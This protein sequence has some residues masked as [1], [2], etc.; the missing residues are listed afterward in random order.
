MRELD[1]G[2]PENLDSRLPQNG[3][4]SSRKSRFRAPGNHPKPG[5]P[6]VSKQRSVFAKVAISSSRQPTKTWIPRYIKTGE[7]VGGAALIRDPGNRPKSAISDHKTAEFGA[8]SPD[9]ELRGTSHPG[10]EDPNRPGSAIST[11]KAPIG[12][13]GA[14][15]TD[16]SI[17]G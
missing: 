12:R 15:E 14:P 6:D 9:F 7:Y 1:R 5:F 11:R 13:T 2:S 16:H 10:P 3:G 17:R 8:G 4:T